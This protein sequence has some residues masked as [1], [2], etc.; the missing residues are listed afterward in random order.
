[1]QAK[2][3]FEGKHLFLRERDGWEY[4]ERKST[5]EAV[6]ILA[7]TDDGRIVFVEQE[8]RPVGARVIEFP[9]GLVGDEDDRA[10]AEATARKELEE[11][12]GFAC[13]TLERVAS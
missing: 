4:A 11:E 8:R 10:D 3:I 9:A 6:V 5:T 13:M 2:S 12:A 1:M 7:R